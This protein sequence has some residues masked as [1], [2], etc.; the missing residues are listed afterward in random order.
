MSD[1]ELDVRTRPMKGNNKKKGQGISAGLVM[2]LSLALLASVVVPSSEVVAGE[3]PKEPIL[4]L[5]TG[6]H[7]AVIK[8]IAVDAANR[9]LVTGSDDKTVRL[10][11]LTSG[12]WLRT[13]RL[14]LGAGYK[15]KI[16]AVAIAPDGE[17]IAAG[18]WTG[19]ERG[20]SHSIY[21]IERSSGRLLH[22][23]TG[24]PDVINHLAYR[25]DGQRLVATLGGKNGIRVYRTTDYTLVSDDRDYDADSYGAHFDT[26]G[27][28]VTTSLD[29]FLRLYDREFRAL[30]KE[31][32]PGGPRPYAV[33]FSPDGTTIAVGYAGAAVV[34]VHAGDTLAHQHSPDIQGGIGALAAVA[35]SQDGRTLYAGGAFRRP[36]RHFLRIWPNAGL[37]A[38]RNIPVTGDTIMDLTPL[39]SGGL[40]FGAHDPAWGV[41]TASDEVSRFHGSAQADYRDLDEGFSLSASG[42][43]VQF[44]YQ[45]EGKLPTLFHMATRTLTV[46]VPPAEAL[47]SPNTSAPG[48]T[49]T[50]WKNTDTPTLNGTPLVLNSYETSRALAIAPDHQTFLLGTGSFLRLFDRSGIQ[51]WQI[52]IPGETSAV[53]ITPN[54]H[55]AVSAFADGTIR[56]YRMR[57]GQELLALYPHGD[58]KRWVLWTPSGFYDASPGAEELI[59]WHVNRG[60]AK[61]ADFFPASRFRSTYYRPNVIDHVLTTLDE[62]QAV[63][64]ADAAVGRRKTQQVV[65]TQRLPPVV[66]ILSPESGTTLSSRTVMLRYSVRTP[67]GDPISSMSVLV[68]GRP[69]AT[70]RD[71]LVVGKTAREEYEATLPVIIPEGACLGTRRDI[72]VVA[73]AVQTEASSLGNCSISLLAKNRNATSEPSTIRVSLE[74]AGLSTAA[75]EFVIKPKLYLLSIG[76]SDYADT[77]LKLGFAAKDARD[78]AATVQRQHGTMYREVVT[79]VLTDEEATRNNIVDGLDW[80]EKET[81]SKDIAMMFLAGHGVNDHKG[82]YY[83]LPVDVNLDHLKRTGVVFS[84]IKHTVSGLAGKTL[85]FVDTCHSGDIMGTRRGVADINAVV[86]ELTSAENGAIVFASS[87]GRQYALEDQAW[88]NGAF[89]K[90]LVEGLQGRA[91]YNG[92][93][94][95]TINMLDLWLSERV[96]ELTQGQQTPT[97]TKPNTIPDFPIALV[98]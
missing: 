48:L 18:G 98:P 47:H 31:R 91:D 87:T 23:I 43:T 25:L 63:K 3:P 96:K 38:G 75:N 64:I 89:T 12:A 8:R 14:P 69:V 7:T 11:D 51:R 82:V 67:S 53:N 73:K 17:T 13:Y 88:N 15:G 93:G 44:A 65:L 33:K 80:L 29:G 66:N 92:S 30:A 24:L 94:R 27:R 36:D 78:F 5:E 35:W 45:P 76:V 9:Y 97:T 90:A 95:I 52:S 58:R 74:V 55:M 83:F 16:Y 77:S 46:N 22:R 84:D 28:L 61:A 70:P 81:T 85:L 72:T 2:S 62:E 49:I 42:R 37:G 41:L 4:R 34:T 21:L 54:G 60:K 39:H 6:M 20:N 32:A 57:D 50:K 56:W 71:I 59:G 40:A 26:Q 19:N 1:K 68:D 10:W 86:N 79:K